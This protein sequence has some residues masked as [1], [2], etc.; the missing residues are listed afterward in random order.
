MDRLPMAPS[1]N[2][3]ESGL[4][5]QLERYRRAARGARLIQRTPRRLVV[6][7]DE[8]VDEK[9]VR[10]AV[11]IERS[12]CPFFALDWAPLQRRLTI[13]VSRSEDVPALDAIEFAL[14]ADV[15]ARSTSAPSE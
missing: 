7:L 5:S 3:D 11:E 6:E 14:G 9:L 10:E 8:R 4:R 12:C 1:C 15:D 13:S 2:L